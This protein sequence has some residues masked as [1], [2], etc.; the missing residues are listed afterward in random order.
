M[1]LR[2]TSILVVSIKQAIDRFFNLL[3]I[4]SRALVITPEPELGCPMGSRE[5]FPSRPISRMGRDF[6][7]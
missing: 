1:L 4:V 5:F 6:R 7:I 3:P 2:I